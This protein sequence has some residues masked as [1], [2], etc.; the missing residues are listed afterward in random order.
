MNRIM[1]GGLLLGL[2]FGLLA[3][4]ASAAD[5]MEMGPNCCQMKMA[6]AQN[7]QMKM[8]KASNHIKEYGIN[9]S[10]KKGEVKKIEFLADKK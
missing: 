8:D 1:K 7:S 9:I 5:K 10:V 4:F 6:M 3:S 2:A